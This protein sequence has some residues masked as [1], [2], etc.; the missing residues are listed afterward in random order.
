MI[1]MKACSLLR[2]IADIQSQ[3]SFQSPCSYSPGD[4]ATASLPEPH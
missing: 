2:G 3:F 1:L 4:A